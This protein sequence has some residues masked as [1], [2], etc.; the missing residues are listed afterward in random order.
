MRIY[1][2]VVHIYVDITTKQTKDKRLLMRLSPNHFR[3]KYSTASIQQMVFDHCVI[4]FS[5]VLSF[6]LKI[7]C[8]RAEQKYINAHHVHTRK[9]KAFALSLS[10]IRV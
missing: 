5:F 4:E 9:D 1:E 3:N 8:E 10:S 2:H 6:R 7:V